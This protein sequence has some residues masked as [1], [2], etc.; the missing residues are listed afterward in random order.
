MLWK[1]LS[2]KIKVNPLTNPKHRNCTEKEDVLN[3]RTN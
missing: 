3:I 1:R 2:S